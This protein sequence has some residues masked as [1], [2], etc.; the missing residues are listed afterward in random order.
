[1]VAAT[2]TFAM[3]FWLPRHILAT[4]RSVGLLF[5]RPTRGRADADLGEP[6]ISGRTFIPA[7]RF[8][9]EPVLTIPHPSVGA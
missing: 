3:Q 4:F 1:M 5:S 7:P 9:V 2:R 8:L 6:F